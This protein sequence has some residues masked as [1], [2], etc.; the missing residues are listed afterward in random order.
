[1]KKLV[2]AAAL[3][4]VPAS[5]FAHHGGV[6]LA[7]GPGSPIETASPMTL[8]EGGFVTGFRIEQIDWK[9]YSHNDDGTP[10]NDN[11]T[12]HTFM[13]ASFNY[14][15]TPA[16]TGTLSVPYYIKRQETLGTNEGMADIKL[17]LTYGF[18]Y[19]PGTGFSRNAASDSAVSME[20]TQ[21]RT[22]MA[23]SLMASIPNGDYNKVRPGDNGHPDRSMQPG[24]GAPSYTLGLTAARVFGP[25][26]LNA[27]LGADFFTPRNDQDGTMQYGTEL[28]GN[29]AG[30]YELYG[31]SN[32]F[33]SKL[34]GIVELNFL[35]LGHD[36]V[37]GVNDAGSGGDIL[38][39][40]PGLRFSFPSFQ[41]A[42]L[43]IAV[44]LPVWTNLNDKKVNAQ[45]SEGV[46]NFRL[47]STISLYF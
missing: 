14:G 11:A 5:A 31:N 4:L 9:K 21:N 22:W 36:R 43:G 18:H 42:N 47:I 17:G 10:K 40:T 24:F 25:L 33:L 29:L 1:M 41:N 12:N 38:Y 34:D 39:L 37:D 8:P 3:M 15:F 23:F 20:S 7:F 13:N 30:I 35:H 16:L 28:R 2:L 45:G 46:E 32:S 6:T 27:E 26:T 19:D 44:K